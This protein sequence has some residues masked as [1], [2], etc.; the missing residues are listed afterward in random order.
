MK[1]RLI[2]APVFLSDGK[3]KSL[4]ELVNVAFEYLI[5]FRWSYFKNRP[6]GNLLLLRALLI[7]GFFGAA[8]YQLVSDFDLVLGGIEIDP[9]I[10]MFAGVVIGYWKMTDVFHKKSE[11]CVRLYHDYLKAMSKGHEREG[12]I[13]FNNFA[14]QILT[15]DLWAHR[16]FRVHFA[17]ALEE[18]LKVCFEEK[19]QTED[20]QALLKEM[21]IHS[22]VEFME[23]IN[24]G[25]LY[26]RQARRLL[27]NHQAFLLSR[28]AGEPATELKAS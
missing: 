2:E 14:M 28:A 22:Q 7:V 4:S 11:T 1:K 13:L 10:A 23:H 27:E 19:Y 9:V 26:A 8:Y 17:R 18:A 15:V 16:S 24:R 21:K 20:A 25:R 12:E 3:I 6:R 5:F